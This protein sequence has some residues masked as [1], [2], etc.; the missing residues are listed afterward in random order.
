MY[1][2]SYSVNENQALAFELINDFPLGLLISNSAGR[3][4][5]NYLPFLISEQNGEI[6]LLSHLAKANT[7]WKRLEGEVLVS[8]Q[9]PNRYVS[10]TIYVD[11]LNVPTWSYATVQIR[12]T[13]ELVSD[14]EDLKD[15]L[16]MTVQFFEKAN[17]SIWEY[18]LPTQMQN[19]LEAAII[20]LKIKII[21]MESKFKL[22]QNRKAGDYEAVVN[23]F[24]ESHD[25]KNKELHKW[26][27][28]AKKQVP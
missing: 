12:G 19:S 7:H 15:I 14:K 16:N 20:G 8:F 13:V 28:K 21:G 2:P 9:G 22:S 23:H 18:E 27:L 3:I 25:P 11:K 24:R 6:I 17:N 10:P 26:M 5:S 1:K 4:E